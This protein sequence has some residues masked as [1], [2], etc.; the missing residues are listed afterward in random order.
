MNSSGIALLV[1]LLI[2]ANRQ[3]QQVLAY[4]LSDHY[5]HI[6]ELTRIDEVIRTY[7]TEG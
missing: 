4:G 5:R 3:S 6:F 7:A 2:R 1:K